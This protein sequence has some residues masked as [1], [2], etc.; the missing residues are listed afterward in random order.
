MTATKRTIVVTGASTGIG[1]ATVIQLAQRGDTVVAGV[2]DLNRCEALGTAAEAAGVEPHIVQMDVTDGDSV[3]QAF[4]DIYHD[5][6]RVDVL[7]NNA[8]VG[9]RGTLEELSIDELRAAMEVNF[10]GVV[11][12][13]K[14]VLPRMRQAGSG[15]V[16][17]V[18]SLGGVLG[19]PFNDAYCASKFAVEGLY[20]SLHPVAAKV[21]V[22]VS[23]VEPGPVATE[24]HANSQGADR[25]AETP[26]DAYGLLRDRYDSL[27]AGGEDRRQPAAEAAAGVIAVIDDP[28]PRLRY[29]TSPFTTKLAGFKIAD[30]SGDA[31]T[32]FTSK[33]LE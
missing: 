25:G 18:T 20:E 23:I 7:V 22:K 19:Q 3:A 12:A 16:I 29:Q 11:R 17:A 13:T 24:F 15:H 32:G 30:L 10:F 4:D 6:R 9:W 33:W 14:A 26:D 8:G 28:S 1:L 5:H 21:G 27:M 2:R 31:V